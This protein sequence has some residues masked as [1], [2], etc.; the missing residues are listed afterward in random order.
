MLVLDG[1]VGLHR[2]GQLQLLQRWWVGQ[3]LNYCDA[4]QFALE[5]NKHHSVIFE[6]VPK[7]CV[8]DPFVDSMG[9]SIPS[10]GFL[11]TLVD[12]MLI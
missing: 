6:I 7:C 5:K 12:I 2:T 11:L 8:L 3:N 10:K 4:E 9:Y 1:P